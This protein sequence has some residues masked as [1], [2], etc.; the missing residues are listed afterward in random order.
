MVIL[1]CVSLKVVIIII[2][3]VDYFNKQDT[4]LWFYKY[5]HVLYLRD[6]IGHWL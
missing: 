2:K 5:I 1:K 4:N 3:I 6:L